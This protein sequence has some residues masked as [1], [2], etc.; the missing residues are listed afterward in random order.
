MQNGFLLQILPLEE[1]ESYGTEHV[2]P[3]YQR[4]IKD[5]AEF[6]GA[7]LP[8][9]YMVLVRDKSNIVISNKKLTI[10]KE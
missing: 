9:K 3:C 1:A 2:V 4:L 6:T 10:I 5:K 8:G 7:L